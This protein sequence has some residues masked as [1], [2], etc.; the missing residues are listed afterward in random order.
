[1]PVYHSPNK[2]TPWRRPVN[3]RQAG[4]WNGVSMARPARRRKGFSNPFGGVF[5]RDNSGFVR[6]NNN[7]I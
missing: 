1:M 7:S 5:G 2:S 4:G 3:S 6:Q